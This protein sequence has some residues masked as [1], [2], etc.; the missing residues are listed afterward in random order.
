MDGVERDVDEPRGFLFL[1]AAQGFDGAKL[2]GVARFVEELVAAMPGVFV[3]TDLAIFVGP[4]I[5]GTGEGDGVEGHRA[6]GAGGKGPAGRS[7]RASGC[8]SAR[9]EWRSGGG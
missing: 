3:R 7:I 5:G 1:D 9:C 4:R 2:G 8:S 6:Q